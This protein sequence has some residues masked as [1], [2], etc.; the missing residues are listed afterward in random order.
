VTWFVPSSNAAPAGLL[1]QLR[2]HARNL[3]PLLRQLLAWWR[4]ELAACVPQRLL[5]WRKRASRIVLSIDG[6]QARL[7]LE[8][9]ATLRPL[10]S[11][12]LPDTATL[13]V[14]ERIKRLTNDRR[15]ARR[16][17]RGTTLRLPASAA[18]RTTLRLPEVVQE[19]LRQVLEF[20]LDRRTPF[21]ASAV[22]FVHRVLAHH[23][24]TRQIEVELTVV[25]R[26]V[27]AD[28]LAAAAAIGLAPIAVDVAPESTDAAASG[29]L[30]RGTGAERRRRLPTM[31]IGGVC[32]ALALGGLAIAL[33]DTHRRADALRQELDEA[34]RLADRAAGV[35]QTIARYS[36]RQGALLAMKQ[37]APAVSDILLEVTRALPDDTWLV[38]LGMAANELRLVGY[39]ASA[40]AL[41]GLIGQ[42]K[43]LA[44]PRFRS[45]V[46]Q[47]AVSSRERFELGVRIGRRPSQ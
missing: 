5:R 4:A 45:A 37:A 2:Q 23:S 20:E 3:P 27:L 31:V 34:R 42:S 46:T 21:A 30:L 6:Q 24:M 35:Q 18:L 40:S 47:D 19:N 15:L 43:L 10:G 13:P 26:A 17:A 39:S 8:T 44:E 41:I 16:A 25:P 28:A 38:E 33:H 7:A 1:A 9:A 11:L 36:E 32:L 22:H 14:T 29:D 12:A